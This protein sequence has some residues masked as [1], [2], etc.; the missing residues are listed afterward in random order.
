MENIIEDDVRKVIDYILEYQPK[1]YFK[2]CTE[3]K[4]NL[5]CHDWFF[6][7]HPKGKF[8]RDTK[9]KECKSKNNT[10]KFKDNFKKLYYDEIKDDFKDKFRYMSMEQL[11]R[12]YDLS[13]N[14]VIAFVSKLK[15]RKSDTISYLKKEEIIFMYISLLNNEIKVFNNGI[16]NYD[17]YI[18]ILI[19]Y[20]IGDILKW[21]RNDICKNYSGKTLKDNGLNGLLGI[22][23]FAA[24]KYLINSFPEYDLKQ[25]ELSASTVGGGFWIDENIKEALDW[26]KNKLLIDKDINNINV[27]KM[28]GFRNLLEEYKLMGLCAVKFDSN[29]IKLFEK[30]YDEKYDR[31]EMLKSYYTFD[32]NNEETEMFLKDKI[33]KLTDSYYELDDRGKTLINAIIR[34]CE[35]ENRFPEEK[36]L[37]NKNGYISRVQFYRYFN[38]YNFK[39]IYDYIIPIYDLSKEVVVDNFKNIIDGQTYNAIFIKPEKIKCIKCGE[40]KNFNNDNFLKG[41][42][43][44]FGLQYECKECHADEALKKRYNLIGIF[45]NNIEDISPEQWW[46]YYQNNI[47]TVMPKH[48][49]SKEN[50]SKIIKYLLVNKL[51]F[52][53]KEKICSNFSYPL[54][55]KY[56]LENTYFII[57][58]L[59]ET[60]QICFPE[61]NITEKDFK[62]L[63]IAFD[64]VKCNSM[65][66]LMVYEFLKL[67]M[68]LEHLKA[69]GLKKSGEHSFKYKNKKIYPDFV[70]D[71]ILY[72][73]YNINMD[74]YLYIEYFGFINISSNYLSSQYRDK[75]KLK[76]EF[77][78]NNNNLYF[79]DLYPDDLKN[80]FKGVRNKINNF[81]NEY[82]SC[83][84]S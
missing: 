39:P 84:V 29:Y 24:N 74:K 20:L 16:Y 27:A 35:K 9:C 1:I 11:E 5:P 46:E 42:L 70:L 25:W 23:K 80:K 72:E 22:K 43:N 18:Y 17:K 61:Y 19:R 21:N 83:K 48:C 78:N 62:T 59:F 76:I 44:R 34:F 58:S 71:K 4:R 37:V 32:I 79:I 53:T 6:T 38:S 10:Y 30:M 69:I 3:C 64:G 68:G 33:Y 49:F 56:K 15:L 55:K 28:S 51:G 52:N 14:E 65:E 50:V 36:E 41:D 12:Y 75:M 45:F 7:K 31:E 13:S 82:I 47:I 66:E 67:E 73:N 26:L 81:I 77:F 57:G 60:L 2:V 63:P 40:E 8:G 54:L